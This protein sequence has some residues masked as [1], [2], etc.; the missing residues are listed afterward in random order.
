MLGISVV[1][2]VAHEIVV[3]TEIVKQNTCSP[4]QLEEES[5][6]ENR[7][8][9]VLLSDLFRRISSWIYFQAFVL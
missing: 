8:A 1:M 2:D 6:R 5:E 3:L 4:E 7:S 9:A